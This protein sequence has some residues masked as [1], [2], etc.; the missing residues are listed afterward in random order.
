M[1]EMQELKITSFT[2]KEYTEQYVR[3]S[4]VAEKP[5]NIQVA[6][7]HHSPIPEKMRF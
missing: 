4:A 3:S 5:C 7:K 2:D 1:S 6:R